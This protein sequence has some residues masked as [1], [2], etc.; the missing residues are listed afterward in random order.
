MK[1]NQTLARMV[2]VLCKEKPVWRGLGEIGLEQVER[3]VKTTLWN[4]G[5][6]VLARKE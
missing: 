1:V 5:E 6:M 2:S 4:I 3:V